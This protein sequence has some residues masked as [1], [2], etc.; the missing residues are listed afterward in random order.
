MFDYST[1]WY[2]ASLSS[3]L[4]N[5]FALGAFCWFGSPRAADDGSIGSV[6]VGGGASNHEFERRKWFEIPYSLFA[7]A[8]LRLAQAGMT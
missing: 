1:T 5:V 7:D 8:W 2:P 4:I 6:V 3:F